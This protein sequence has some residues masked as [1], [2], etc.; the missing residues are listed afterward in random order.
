MQA[1]QTKRLI[2][3]EFVMEDVEA[4]YNFSREA[5]LA[6]WMPDQVYKNLDEAKATLQFLIEQYQ[7]KSFP[8]VMAVVDK[9]TGLLIG[10]VG[11]SEIE[12]G[13]EIGYAIGM[14]YQGQ[15]YAKEAVRAYVNRLEQLLGLDKIYGV[16]EVGNIGS[17]K[18]LEAVGFEYH[19]L[20]GAGAKKVYVRCK[21]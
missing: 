21:K 17:A 3:R 20:D 12:E 18:V 1:I 5:T 9:E 13:I 15:G 10:H 6:Q 7:H 19:S 11:L 8:L 16:V 14:A 4:V 2:I